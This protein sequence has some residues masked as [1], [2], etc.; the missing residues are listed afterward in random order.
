MSKKCTPLWREAHFQVKTYKT[1]HV[2]TTFGSWDVEKVHAAVARVT[3]PSQNV[4]NTPRSDHF[5]KLRCRKSARGCGGEAHF[6]VKSVKNWGV[7][8]T[9]WLSDVDHHNNNNNNYYYYYY[10]NYYHNYCY[11]YY[12]YYCYYCYYYYYH[13]YYSNY[14]YNYNYNYNNYNNYNNHNN[15]NHYSYTTTT[16]TTTTSP[17]LQLQLQ[18]QLRYNYTT[19]HYTKLHYTNYNCN[20]NRNYNYAT[21]QYTTLDYIALHYSTLHY[22]RPI[23]PLQYDCNYT[24]LITLHH[25]YNSTTLQLRL[26]LQYTTLHPAVVGEVTIATIATTPTNTTPT[27][28]LSISGFALPSVIHNN[29]PLL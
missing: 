9:F 12:C 3:C 23:T 15:Y 19:L 28:F 10:Y 20:H 21:F 29:Q 18:L 26:Q 5:W 2:Q 14:N 1:R 17:Q 6:Q 7:P 27:T 4:Q 22:T 11:Y 16:T 8:A 25:N 24:T 13:Y